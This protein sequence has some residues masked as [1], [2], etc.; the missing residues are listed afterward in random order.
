MQP[1]LV[2]YM[3]DADTQTGITY[4]CYTNNTPRLIVKTTVAG[5]LTTN[6]KAFGAWDDRASLTYVPINA[7]NPEEQIITPP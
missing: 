6:E 1:E 7:Q 3:V 2:P 5:N 4:T